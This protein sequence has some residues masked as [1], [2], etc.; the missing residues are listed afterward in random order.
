MK[1][2]VRIEM[3]RLTSLILFALTLIPLAGCTPTPPSPSPEPVMLQYIGHSCTLITA[4][5]GTRVL[6]DPYYTSRPNGLSPFPDDIEA[7]ALTISHSHPDHARILDG[8]QI[9]WRPG[10][11]QVGMVKI[12]GY[13]GDHGLI[14]GESTGANI[15]FVFEIGEI[16]IVHMGAAGV[17]TQPDILAAMENADVIILD[18]HGDAAHPLDE[19]IAQMPEVNARTVIPTHYSCKE[20]SRYFGAVTLDEFLEFLPAETEI[21]RTDSEIQIVPNMPEQIAILTPLTLEE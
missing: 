6:S 15:V 8:P 1:Q 21:M 9:L 10:S 3:K 11:Y 17:V 12:T 7:D 14:D 19:Q 5:D 13:E 20:N 2:E 18:I 4:P 16:K